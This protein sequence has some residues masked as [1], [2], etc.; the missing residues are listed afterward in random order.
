MII[1]DLDCDV[2]NLT[3][4]DFSSESFE[5]AHY[6]MG[7]VGLHR[8]ASKMF[9]HHCSPSRLH[10]CVDPVTRD[11]AQQDILSTLQNW[12]ASHL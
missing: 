11:H 12:H 1:N 9:F 7:Q 10:I 2:E 5:T 8:A 6:V 4:S 3:L